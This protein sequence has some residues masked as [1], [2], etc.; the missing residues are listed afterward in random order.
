MARLNEAPAGGGTIRMLDFGCGS[1]TFTERLL[2]MAAWSPE[3]LQ[4]TLVEPAEA[5][6]REAVERLAAFSTALVVD[7]AGMP[8]DAAEGF[9]FV[10]ANHVLYYVEDVRR[11]VE[12]L[13]GALAAGGVFAAAVAGR[14]NALIGIWIKAFALIGRD[15]PYHTSEDV[16]AA[17][18]DLGAEYE[19]EAVPYELKLADSRENR[20]HIIR[21]LLADHLHQMPLEPLVDMF[22]AYSRNGHVEIRT[23]SDHYTVRRAQSSRG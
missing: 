4:L 22:D 7:A 23:S 6:R 21:F 9:E 17:L 18:V 10:L 2:R 8:A 1:G 20:M 12:G 16:E 15:I 11:S 13:I 19:K 3:R 14:N 5:V